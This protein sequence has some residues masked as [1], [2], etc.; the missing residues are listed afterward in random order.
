MTMV[1]MYHV[2]SLE[3]KIT[4]IMNQLTVIEN[5]VKDLEL[6]IKRNGPVG[7]QQTFENPWKGISIPPPPTIRK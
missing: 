3:Y 1:E 4:E 7:P 6:A 5:R 2:K